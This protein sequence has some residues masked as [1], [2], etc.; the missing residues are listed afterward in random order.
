M[1]VLSVLVLQSIQPVTQGLLESLGEG[2]YPP[3]MTMG[4][5]SLLSAHYKEL[6]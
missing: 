4:K 5:E 6:A 2:T 1:F 3:W